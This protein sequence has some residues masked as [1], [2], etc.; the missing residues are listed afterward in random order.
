MTEQKDPLVEAMK[1]LKERG[2]NRVMIND[3]EAVPPM[4]ARE[5]YGVIPDIVFLRDDGWML[6]APESLEAAAHALWKDKWVGFIRRPKDPSEPTVF[7][8]I[9]EYQ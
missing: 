4:R 1:A 5:E 8:L 3:D 2:P 7:K 9:S 6:G